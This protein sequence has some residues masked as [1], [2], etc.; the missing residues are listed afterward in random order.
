M[1]W[2]DLLVLA[3]LLLSALVGL[4]R[5]FVREALGL[6][7]WIAAAV[8]AFQ[9]SP[10][11]EPLARR[12]I[13]DASVADPVAFLV[14]FGVLLIAFLLVAAALG[15]LVRGSVLGGLDRLA[16]F[17]FGLLRGFAVLVVAYLVVVPLLPVAGWPL[18]L[19]ASRALPPVRS[20]AAFVVPRLPERFRPDL[21]PPP[22]DAGAT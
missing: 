20:A 10:Q 1:N 14:V 4:L 16:G 11:A 18:A 21:D 8:L 22:A 5:G 13:G 7:A 19:R 2:V 9:F 17:G 6:C 12:V 15:G 3:L